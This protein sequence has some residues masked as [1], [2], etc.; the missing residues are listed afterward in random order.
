VPQAAQQRCE[1]PFAHDR[2][3]HALHAIGQMMRA[4]AAYEERPVIGEDMMRIRSAGSSSRRI[5]SLPLNAGRRP[6][7]RSNKCEEN[8]DLLDH[9]VG[10]AEQHRR[11]GETGHHEFGLSFGSLMSRLRASDIGNWMLM[12]RGGI[13]LSNHCV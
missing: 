12:P 13:E 2:F 1:R 11:D 4:Q 3:R 5:P 7:S 9:L 6:L 8:K 10:A